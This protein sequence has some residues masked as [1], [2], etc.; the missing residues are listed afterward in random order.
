[1]DKSTNPEL[2]DFILESISL[3]K[4]RFKDI[5]TS[6]DF[7]HSDEGLDKLDGISMRLQ[8]IGEALKNIHKRDKEFL[9]SVESDKYW[10][11]IIRTRDF[12]SH[13]YVE[14]DSETIFMICDEKIE[15]LE[16]NILKLQK[17]CSK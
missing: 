7:L 16:E 9:L 1:M 13:H 3:I 17:Q 11:N 2:L 4:R 15:Y 10:S 12:I 6:D 8:A 5:D 14:L